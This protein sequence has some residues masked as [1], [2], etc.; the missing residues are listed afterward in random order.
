MKSKFIILVFSAILFCLTSCGSRSHS[1]D[2][3]NCTEHDH[4]THTHADGTVHSDHPPEQE[5]F[6]VEADN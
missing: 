6:K 3:E 4:N 2:H 5:S 1:H